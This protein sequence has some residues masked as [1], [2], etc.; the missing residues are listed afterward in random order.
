MSNANEGQGER[1]K[2]REMLKLRNWTCYSCGVE[3]AD[4]LKRV[5]GVDDVSLNFFTGQVM[6]EHKGADIEGLKKKVK[7]FGMEL[8]EEG[9]R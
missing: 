9:M 6:V 8:S 1:A 3:L 5:K 7:D 2:E 4:R